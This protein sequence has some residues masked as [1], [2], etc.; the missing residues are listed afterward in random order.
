MGV[1]KAFSSELIKVGGARIWG[2]ITTEPLGSVV[3]AVDPEYVRAIRGVDFGD[4]EEVDT[5]EEC[6]YR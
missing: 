3:L 6:K 1:A 4:G 5:G 2:T